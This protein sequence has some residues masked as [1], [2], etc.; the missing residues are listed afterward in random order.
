MEIGFWW[1]GIKQDVEYTVRTCPA[2][3][4]N[5][6]V[7]KKYG[8]LPPKEAETECTPWERVNVDLVGP[9]TVTQPNGASLALRALTMIDPAT[10]W[11]EIKEVKQAS[12]Q[13]VS[14]A[15]DDAWLTRYPRPKYIGF[16]NGGEN[17][18]MFSQMMKNCGLKNK[19]T[20]SYN[21]QSNG[22]VERVHAVLNDMLRT[23]E[24]EERELD[25]NDP[26]SEILSSIAFAIRA[27]YHTTLQAT[28][29][30]L[31]FGRDMIL[32]IAIEAD[33]Q[34][35]KQK[36]QDEINRNNRRKILFHCHELSLRQRGLDAGMKVF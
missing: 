18:G 20:T 25:Q 23:Y 36:K 32:P 30:Q 7:R 11:F 33:W 22:V 10:G 29:A 14:E 27:T 31:V 5:K 24:L 3:Q 4:K 26:F 12:S 1:S 2:C 8:E 17:K 34:L 13:A 9:F 21:P 6:R 16:D 15:F 28:P 35:I 19:P